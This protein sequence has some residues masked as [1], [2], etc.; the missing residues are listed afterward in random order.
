MILKKHQQSNYQ[1]YLTTV[2]ERCLLEKYDKAKIFGYVQGYYGELKF[3]EMI[4]A[5]KN[6]HIIWDVSL[7]LPN[8]CQYDFIVITE[9]TVFHFEVKNF[10]GFYSYRRGSFKSEKGYVQKDVLQQLEEAHHNLNGFLAQHGYTQKLVSRIVLIND[11]LE[12]HGFDG[13]ERFLFPADLKKVQNYLSSCN[14]VTK[15]MT[16]L[17]Q[18]LVKLHKQ[19]N[20]NERIHYYDFNQLKKGLKCTNCNA[21]AI[22][23]IKQKQAMKCVRCGHK[24]SNQ[25]AVLQ[26]YEEIETLTNRL[27]TKKEIVEWTGLHEKTVRRLLMKNYDFN[28][29]TS[30]RK[31]YRKKDNHF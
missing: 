8:R 31:Y 15:E 27:P 20:P 12:L 1:K 3:F 26:A 10:S 23:G 6:I 25:M 2:H 24:I 30:D 5:F 18:H 19:A 7:E 21:I 9:S 14:V 29:V 13:D 22:E 11:N 16:Q 28:G 17:G 4:K